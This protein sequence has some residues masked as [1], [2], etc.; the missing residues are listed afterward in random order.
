MLCILR[1]ADNPK[2]KISAFKLLKLLPGIGPK[3]A[4]RVFNDLE[5]HDFALG[6][7]RSFALSESAKPSFLSLIDL[8]DNV[9]HN[10]IP[11]T[12]QTSAIAAFYKDLL[13]ANYDDHFTRYGDVEQLIMIS[14]QYSSR[15][16][17]LTELRQ[18]LHKPGI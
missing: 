12:E 9:H 5:K 15:E 4:E 11:W 10:N 16:R 7:L 18:I 17:F 13:E 1:W 8:L 14:G 3:I 2:H 6:K